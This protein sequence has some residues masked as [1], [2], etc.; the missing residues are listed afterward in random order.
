MLPTMIPKPSVALAMCRKHRCAEGC[1]G[2]WDKTT[3]PVLPVH[4]ILVFYFQQ[5][6]LLVSLLNPLGVLVFGTSPGA[7]RNLT[8]GPSPAEP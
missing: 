8:S 2:D 4:R 7:N 1:P 5:T 6:A 3:C